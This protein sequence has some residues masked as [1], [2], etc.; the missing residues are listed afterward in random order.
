MTLTDPVP[1]EGFDFA[2][3]VTHEMGHFLGLAHSGDPH[4]TMYASYTPGSTAMRNLTPDDMSAICTV[5]AA[6]GTRAVAT[7]V[8]PSGKLTMDPCDPA[9][10]HGFSP[11]CRTDC[12]ADGDCATGQMCGER[13][14]CVNTV[15]ASVPPPKPPAH[16]AGPTIDAS[17]RPDASSTNARIATRGP[18]DEA[19][20]SAPPP[21]PNKPTGGAGSGGCSA[22]DAIGP[23]HAFA[24][25]WLLV[26]LAMI[27]RA[28]KSSRRRDEVSPP[29]RSR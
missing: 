25:A 11:Y 15:D 26:A 22:T 27:A 8:A 21:P 3:V 12:S 2:S 7:S 13:G 19:P 6:D 24:G 23:I 16:D 20:P 18:G 28:L 17:A 14:A 10:R 1:Y 5:Y 4:A 9:P 29:D